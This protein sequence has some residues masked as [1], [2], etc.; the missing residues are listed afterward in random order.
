MNA[1]FS[2]NTRLWIAR[3]L[4]GMVVF[5]NLQSAAAFLLF[6]ER[7][8]QSYELTGIPGQA[9]LRGFA[10]LF[11]MWNVPYLFALSHPIRRR[12]SLLESNLMQALGLAG[13]S[14]LL[15]RIDPTFPLLRASIVRF[16]VFDAAG[17]I[18][19]L[20]ALVLTV[21]L[22]SQPRQHGRLTHPVR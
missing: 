16:I 8:I 13:E 12:I 6:P 14:W 18:L 1:V 15:T 10:I 7:Y 2:R 5:I 9:A 21:R 22:E 19:L 3:G 11:C 17:L 4:I 20:L